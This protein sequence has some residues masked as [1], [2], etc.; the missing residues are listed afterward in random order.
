MS[1]L[2]TVDFY[3]KHAPVVFDYHTQKVGNGC[4]S[5]LLFIVHFCSQIQNFN[6]CQIF[7]PVISTLFSIICIR[8][9]T[10]KYV[11]FKGHCP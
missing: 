3:K 9:A 6:F 4:K 8:S 5:Y 11:I 7:V 10:K 2:Y 1:E